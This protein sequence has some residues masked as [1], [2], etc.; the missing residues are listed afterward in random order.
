M[1]EPQRK[2]LTQAERKAIYAAIGRGRA[3]DDRDPQE[4][5]REDYKGDEERYLRVM[6]GWHHVPIGQEVKS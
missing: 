4:V 1:T 6:A 2:P 3:P 5:I